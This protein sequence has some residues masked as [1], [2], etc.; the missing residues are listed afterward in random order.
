MLHTAFRTL[1][2]QKRDNLIK[3]HVG[4]DQKSKYAKAKDIFVI[5]TS[6]CPKYT[7]T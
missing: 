2:R 6:A 3:V 4:I 7:V 5:K 1:L